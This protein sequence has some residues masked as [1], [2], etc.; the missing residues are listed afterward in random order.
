MQSRIKCVNQVK[1][2][3]SYSWSFKVVEPAFMKQEAEEYLG[4][5]KIDRL[6][7]L[8]LRLLLNTA[9]ISHEQLKKSEYILT[10]PFVYVNL[11]YFELIHS[12]NLMRKINY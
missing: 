12:Q 1:Q 10:I 9:L 6:V 5:G 4:K 11:I 3:Y 8:V 7:D 2:Y